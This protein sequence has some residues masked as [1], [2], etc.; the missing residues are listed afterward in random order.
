MQ[1]PPSGRLESVFSPN[2]G[3]LHNKKDSGLVRAVG[4]WGG[5]GGVTNTHTP[6]LNPFRFL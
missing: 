6:K 3:S 4:G 2:A 5:G 1:L